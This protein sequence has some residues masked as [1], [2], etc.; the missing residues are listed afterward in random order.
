MTK[1]ER[2][3]FDD[4]ETAGSWAAKSSP[5]GCVEIVIAPVPIQGELPMPRG[6]IMRSWRDD[7]KDALNWVEGIAPK[8]FGIGYRSFSIILSEDD[9]TQLRSGKVLAIGSTDYRL[10]FY[11]M[12]EVEHDDQG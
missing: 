11:I 10:D 9:L 12:I 8:P 3:W 5:A 7:E 6:L 2:R 1:H 4:E